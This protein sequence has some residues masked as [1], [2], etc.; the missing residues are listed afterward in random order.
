MRGEGDEL[1]S[2]SVACFQCE[3]HLDDGA[4]WCSCLC[5]ER[6]NHGAVIRV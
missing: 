1:V 6:T 5:G 4:L 2:V 3:D